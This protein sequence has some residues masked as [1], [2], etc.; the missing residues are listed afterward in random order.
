MMI[1]GSIM[2]RPKAVGFK[3][4]TRYPSLI[5]PHSSATTSFDTGLRKSKNILLKVEFSY[6]ILI[7]YLIN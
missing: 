4:V 6:I 1:S 7:F 2:F 3:S 5:S